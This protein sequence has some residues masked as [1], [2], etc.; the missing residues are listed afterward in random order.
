MTTTRVVLPATTLFGS[1]V[2]EAGYKKP[3]GQVRK[4]KV[5]KGD[6]IY[7]ITV[8]DAETGDGFAMTR[9]KDGNFEVE[10]WKN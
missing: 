1:L 10:Y 4:L 2:K 9:L 7:V 3:K 5:P 8:R 6:T